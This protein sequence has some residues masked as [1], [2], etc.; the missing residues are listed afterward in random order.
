MNHI[1]R[2]FILLNVALFPLCAPAQSEELAAQRVKLEKA[3]LELLDGGRRTDATYLA[4]ISIV[5]NDGVKT[6]WRM[7]GDSGLPPVFDFSASRNVG[8]VD[9]AWPAPQRLSEADGVILGFKDR[10]IFPLIV[11]PRDPAQAVIL[12][13]AIDFGLCD[14]LCLPAKAALSRDLK[15]P[16]AEASARADIETFLARV[17]H[18][19]NLKDAV[20]PSVVAVEP[21]NT[22]ALALAISIRSATPLKDLIIEGPDG[23]YFGVGTITPAENGLYRVV[24]PIEQKPSSGKLGGL[25]L[26]L[27]AISA[28]SATETRL[29]LDASGAIR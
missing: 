8:H 11:T 15:N 7:P 22:P 4:G 29:T 16:S 12:Q 28:G 14:T 6:Y 9:I 10:V 23:W 19:A 3:S 5:L 1:V 20:S 21:T 18:Q 2:L 13:V 17:P 24:A 27:T 26:T 25:S